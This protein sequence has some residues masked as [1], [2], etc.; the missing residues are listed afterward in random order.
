MTANAAPAAETQLKTKIFISYSREDL[1]FADWLEAAL[2]ARG[3]EVF[4]DRQKIYAFEDWWGRIEALIARA[5]A[6]GFETLMLNAQVAVE[7]FYR[8]MGFTPEGAHF[9]EADIEHV[10]MMLKL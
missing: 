7:G 1:A 10:R 9:I 8:A 5:K 3:F 4:I 2:K 6:R